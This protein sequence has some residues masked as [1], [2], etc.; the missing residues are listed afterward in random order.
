MSTRLLFL[1]L[2]LLAAV[3]ALGGC[4][5]LDP[6]N[7]AGRLH[8]QAQAALTRWA[9][10]VQAAGG[11][12]AV[13]PIGDLTGQVGD[14]EGANGDNKQVLMAGLVEIAGPLSETRPADGS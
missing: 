8:Q 4:S 7:D 14:W 10:G 6:W 12:P 9:D 2:G 11:M 13:V 5:A 1:A 3:I